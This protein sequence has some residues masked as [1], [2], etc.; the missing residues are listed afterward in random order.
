MT[1]QLV[2]NKG[3][4]FLE[5]FFSHVLPITSHE[6]FC[7]EVIA[8]LDFLPTNNIYSLQKIIQGKF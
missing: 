2:P 3:L 8:L 6:K 1:I 7:V 5:L 4:S